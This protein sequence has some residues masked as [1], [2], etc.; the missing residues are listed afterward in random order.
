MAPSTAD[1]PA[2][3]FRRTGLAVVLVVILFWAWYVV[4][5]RPNVQEI[6]AATYAAFVKQERDTDVP[7]NATNIHFVWSSVG[8]GG[9]ARACRFEAPLEDLKAYAIADSS[10]YAVGPSLKA[11]AFAKLT[12]PARR[13]NLSRYGIQDLTWFDVER[14]QEGITL[15][16]GDSHAPITLIDTRRNVLYSYWTD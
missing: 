11:P 8:L 4:F 10:G 14:I 12:E 13:P 1:R 16:R 7:K 15:E 6:S 3:R 5:P 9:R 2:I